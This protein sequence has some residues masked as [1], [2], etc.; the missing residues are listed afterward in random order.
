MD[1]AQGLVDG[2]VVAG[3]HQRVLQPVPHRDVVV[4]V[5]GR[6]HRRAR[7]VGQRCQVAVTLDVTLQ[8]VLLELHVHRVIAEPV[9]VVVQELPGLDGFALLQQRGQRPVA[10]AGQQYQP[11]RM[12]SQQAWVELGILAVSSVG[13]GEQARQVAV[14]LP[15]LGQQCQSRAVR[16]RQ[17]AAE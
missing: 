7:P 16:Q 5:V 13:Q 11:A 8:K 3:S 14:A 15:R 9:Q 6:H 17:L 12:F 10:P 2:G 4:H 1:V